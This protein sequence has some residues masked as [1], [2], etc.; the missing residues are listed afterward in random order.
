MKEDIKKEASKQQVTTAPEEDR[1]KYLT[2]CIS[3]LTKLDADL[4]WRLPDNIRTSYSQTEMAEFFRAFLGMKLC[5]YSDERI[6]KEF[7]VPL[8]TIKN[9][10]II[11]QEAVY[12]AIKRKR[13]TGIPL[14][15]EH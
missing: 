13:E 4:M 8:N 9:L 6:A 7:G 12:R 1:Y 5:H 10:D 14:V 3:L 2:Y 15:G 11:G